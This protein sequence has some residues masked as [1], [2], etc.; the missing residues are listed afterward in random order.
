MEQRDKFCSGCATELELKESGGAVRPVCP[1]CGRVVY[2]DPKV[3]A[4]TL[5]SRDEKVLLVRRANLLGY[6][7]WSVPGGYVDRGEVVE[8]AAARE[9]LEETGLKVKIDGLV[10]L[11]SEAGRPVIVAAFS[12][13]ET[14]GELSPGPEALDAGFFALD[15]LPPMA[16]PGDSNILQQ[17]SQGRKG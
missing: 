15:D 13:T 12:G 3:A 1:A 11:F 6:G 14:G 5:I 16:F 9:V 8:V 7:L 17:W 10:G 4:V 2:Y